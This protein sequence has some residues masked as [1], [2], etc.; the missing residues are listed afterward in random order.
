MSIIDSSLKEKE[1]DKEIEE[2]DTNAT[3]DGKSVEREAQDAYDSSWEE[4]EK[5][6][7][8]REA[9]KSCVA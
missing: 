3:L 6:G 5:E 7:E 9:P 2:M 8:K 1:G 4:E